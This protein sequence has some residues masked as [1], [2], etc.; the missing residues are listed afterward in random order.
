MDQLAFD[1]EMSKYILNSIDDENPLK[2]KYLK[3]LAYTKLIN[4]K[5]ALTG[6]EVDLIELTN[7]LM[8]QNRLI[9]NDSSFMKDFMSAMY[10]TV[11]LPFPSLF[12]FRSRHLFETLELMAHD[13]YYLK[14]KDFWLKSEDLILRT[15]GQL[16]T[17][18]LA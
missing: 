8:D 1:A 4:K 7:I 13:E 15:K 12:F 16:S 3:S 14:E 2:V 5:T 17:E 11:L 10:F 6:P 18:Q 9:K